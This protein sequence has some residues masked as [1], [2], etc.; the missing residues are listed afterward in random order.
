MLLWT[1]A[2]LLVDSAK[3]V[4]AAED[5]QCSLLAS[6]CHDETKDSGRQC[7]LVLANVASL[8]DIFLDMIYPKP[9]DN[10]SYY[11][12]TIIVD[13]CPNKKIL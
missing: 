2:S 1:N 11:W 3:Y 8:C 6:E 9:M 4:L 7:W 12:I 10:T 13:H 5:T